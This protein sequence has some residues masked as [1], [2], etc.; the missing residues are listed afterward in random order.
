[1]LLKKMDIDK[2]SSGSI[3]GDCVQPWD[4][5]I[6]YVLLIFFFFLEAPYNSNRRCDHDFL[7]FPGLSPFVLF[8]CAL[9]I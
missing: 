7:F 5:V 1:M 8:F 6:L 9:L 2:K 3:D 4:I